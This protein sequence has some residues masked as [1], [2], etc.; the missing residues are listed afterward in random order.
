MERSFVRQRCV[1][2]SQ[3]GRGV[4]FVWMGTYKELRSMRSSLSFPAILGSGGEA[5]SLVAACPGWQIA[6]GPGLVWEPL[7]GSFCN[8]KIRWNLVS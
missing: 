5:A 4:A 8:L 7:G 1:R 2:G 3:C 6:C